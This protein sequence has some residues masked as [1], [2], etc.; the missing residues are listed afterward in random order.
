MYGD[1]LDFLR[2]PYSAAAIAERTTKPGS[3]PYPGWHHLWWAFLYY[4]KSAKMGAA[5]LRCGVALADGGG[6]NGIC[7]GALSGVAVAGCDVVLDA[8][9]FYAYSVAY[10]SV[11]IFLPVWFP[12]SYYNTRYGMELLPAFALFPAFAVLAAIK[13]G[14]NGLVDPGIRI[15]ADR[16]QQCFPDARHSAGLAGSEGKRRDADSV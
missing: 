8:G 12:H 5:P 10:G 6:R 15:S 14:R 16:G 13:S 11:P 9:P 1:P 3:L 4:V 7:A 2:G